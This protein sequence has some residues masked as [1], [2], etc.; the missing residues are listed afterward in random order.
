MTP[1]AAEWAKVTLRL[2]DGV[3]A[4]VPI[5]DRARS[6]VALPGSHQLWATA[7]KVLHYLMKTNAYDTLVARHLVYRSLTSWC[8]WTDTSL[9]MSFVKR[10]CRQVHNCLIAASDQSA[11]SYTVLS[12]LNTNRGSDARPELP[13]LALRPTS[14]RTSRLRQA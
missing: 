7:C 9:I 14:L 13:T 2:S 1:A 3:R 12:S 4:A 10:M 8:L 11:V 5:P 6:R